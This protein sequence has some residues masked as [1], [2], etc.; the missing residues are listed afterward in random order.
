MVALTVYFDI[1]LAVAFK[2]GEIQTIFLY[3]ILWQW[4]DS[5]P[6][7][8]FIQNHLPFRHL[9]RV[10]NCRITWPKLLGGMLTLY[11][12]PLLKVADILGKARQIADRKSV[13]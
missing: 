12:L 5:S 11:S 7:Q 10:G 1:Q 6:I 3:A 2:Q 8:R 9:F 13:V 4:A